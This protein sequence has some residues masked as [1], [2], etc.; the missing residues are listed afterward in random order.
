MFKAWLAPLFAIVIFSA[1]LFLPVTPYRWLLWLA[2]VLSIIAVGLII[3]RCVLNKQL[4]SAGSI[5]LEKKELL[6]IKR[7]IY[8]LDKSILILEWSIFILLVTLR[9]LNGQLLTHLTLK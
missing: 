6:D 5:G 3:W 9:F 1:L 2:G 8:L 7:K 4:K